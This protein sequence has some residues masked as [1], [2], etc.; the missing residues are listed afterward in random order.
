MEGEVQPQEVAWHRI[1]K[2]KDPLKIGC[3]LLLP[4]MF[5]AGNEIVKGWH[6]FLSEIK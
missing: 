3:H 6:G 1:K 5:P 2:R 4:Y